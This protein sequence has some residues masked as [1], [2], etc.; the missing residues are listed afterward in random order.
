MSGKRSA[1]TLVM[2]D[3]AMTLVDGRTLAFTDL[4]DADAP[5]VF[6]FHG[7]PTSRLDL[8]AYEAAFIDRRVRVVAHGR[9]TAELIPNARFV[10]LRGQGHVILIRE[11]PQLCADLLALVTEATP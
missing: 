8:V 11:I 2:R 7:A 10:L 3:D 9:H 5:V 1:G 6:Y 4:G